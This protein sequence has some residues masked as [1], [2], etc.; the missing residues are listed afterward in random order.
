LPGEL[1]VAGLDKEFKECMEFS[2]RTYNELASTMPMQA[3]YVVNFAFKYPYFMKMNL[4]E[5]CH[6]IE[7]RTAPQGH[8]DYRRVCQSIYREIS[9]VHPVLSQ[10]IKF[11]DMNDYNLERLDSE[12]RTER[13]RQ[14]N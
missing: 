11:A 6:L 3:Q 8:P 1:V 7:L 9:K 10:G 14:D 5:A 12:K 2:K 13:K 4:R